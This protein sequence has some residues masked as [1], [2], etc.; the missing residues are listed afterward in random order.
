MVDLVTRT[1]YST[2]ARCRHIIIISPGEFMLKSRIVA[3]ALG[4]CALASLPLVAKADTLTYGFTYNGTGI[5]I[6]NETAT[7]SGSFTI[8]FDKLGDPTLTAFSFTD[9]LTVPKSSGSSYTYSLANFGSDSIVLGGT[10]TNPFLA[11]LQIQT[12]AVTG[13]DSSYGPASFGFS[14]ASVNPAAG[15]TLGTSGV[16][17][18]DFTIGNVVLGAP[19]LQTTSTVPE[20]ASYVLLATGLGLIG[21][22]F[23]FRRTQRVSSNRI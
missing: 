9:I 5:F 12:S 11:N 6:N 23:L 15:N 14:Y 22:A 16:F 21:I 10:L 19:T 18:D 3:L 2:D 8:S 20:P 4:L 7:G 17:L 13:T 1:T